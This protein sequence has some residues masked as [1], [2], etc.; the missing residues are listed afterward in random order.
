MTLADLKQHRSTWD[1]PIHTNYRGVTVYECP[2]NGQGLTALIALNIAEQF[3]LAALPWHFA[4]APP[5][6]GRIHAPGLGRRP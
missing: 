4:P 2:P 1:E 3:D 6:H 5:P